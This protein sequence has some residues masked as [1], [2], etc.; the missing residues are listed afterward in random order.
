MHD[1]AHKYSMHTL[2][3]ERPA[4]YITERNNGNELSAAAKQDS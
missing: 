2:G 4:D 1:G 3:Y